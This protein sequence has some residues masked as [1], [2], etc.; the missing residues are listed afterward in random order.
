MIYRR[1]KVKPSGKCEA[2]KIANSF[3]YRLTNGDTMLISALEVLLCTL[4]YT[5]Q[6]VVFHVCA[7]LS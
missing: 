1:L 2:A 5:A 4:H 3:S 7:K 6:V